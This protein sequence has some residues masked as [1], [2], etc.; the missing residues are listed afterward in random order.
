MTAVL[1]PLPVQKFFDNNGAPLAFGFLYTYAAGTTTPQASY[2]DSTQT[3][4][5]T[6]P[7]VLNARG[8]CAL[9]LN[10]ALSYKLLLTDAIGNQIPGWPVD[11][12]QGAIVTGVT[13]LTVGSP[14]SGPSL[15]VNSAAL[16]QAAL[17]TSTAQFTGPNKL[18]NSNQNVALTQIMIH[19]RDAEWVTINSG[20]ALDQK[21]WSNFADSSGNYNYRIENDALSAT[22]TYMQVSRTGN[23]GVFG[24]HQPIVTWQ[25]GYGNVTIASTVA[26]AY[27]LA[28]FG[29]SVAAFSNGL[30][31]GAGT[32]TLDNALQIVDSTNTHIFLN[33]RGDGKMA[34]G[35]ATTANEVSL[36]VT[37]QANSTGAVATFGNTASNFITVL[38]GAGMAVVVQASTGLGA[39]VFGTSSNHGVLINAHAVTAINI[40]NAGSI[41]FFG[42]A[43]T[44]QPT[45]AVGS[46]TFVV[47]AGTAVNTL[48]TFDG[49][50]LPQ[51]V[52]ALRNLG[53]LA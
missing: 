46:A 51:V 44:V 38:D 37:G 10:P 50:T 33:V 45:T 20:G 43:G 19:G 22:F 49:Y 31:I 17:F 39:A 26:G 2:I 41:G 32:G 18:T 8:E 47:N 24:S 27:Q 4:Q 9:W 12:I 53:I 14:V 25:I 5:N 35:P 34:V 15:T 30:H 52:K 42:S 6:N 11:N 7:I 40:G 3:T 29:G 16:W 1:S 21:V 48:S 28:V 36:A 13:S 23:G